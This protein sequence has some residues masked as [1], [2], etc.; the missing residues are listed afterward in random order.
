MTAQAHRLATQSL[1]ELECALHPGLALRVGI[2]KVYIDLALTQTLDQLPG[3]MSTSTKSAGASSA[4]GTV[5]RMR[6]PAI[7]ATTSLRLS[8]GQSASGLPATL[9]SKLS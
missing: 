7:R 9:S 3:V 6:T 1:G 5:S 8:N 4:S 2:A